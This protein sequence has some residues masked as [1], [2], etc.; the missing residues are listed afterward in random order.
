MRKKNDKFN[1]SIR[2][3]YLMMRTI[4]AHKV[5][6]KLN[7]QDELFNFLT[8]QIQLLYIRHNLNSLAIDAGES[9]IQFFERLQ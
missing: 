1:I 5:I 4:Y 9:P 2:Y 7:Q 8:Q 3:S 6:A